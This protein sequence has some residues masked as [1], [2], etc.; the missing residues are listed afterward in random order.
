MTPLSGLESGAGQ[1]AKP[2]ARF[3]IMGYL[4]YHEVSLVSRRCENWNE[5]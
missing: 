2:F 3:A 4:L 1:A 5:R